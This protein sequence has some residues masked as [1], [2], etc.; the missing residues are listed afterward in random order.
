MQEEKSGRWRIGGGQ[1]TQPGQEVRWECTPYLLVPPDCPIHTCPACPV[2]NLTSP[3][4]DRN[5]AKEMKINCRLTDLEPLEL[6]PPLSTPSSALLHA[7]PPTPPLPHSTPRVSSHSHT[8]PCPR[9]VH[10]ARSSHAIRAHSSPALTSLSRRVQAQFL[11]EYK[12]V[13]VG[14][15]GVGKSSLTI[16]FI[17]AHFVDEYDPTIVRSV[18]SSLAPLAPLD[19]RLD[20]ERLGG[21]EEAG[22]GLG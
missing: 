12:L 19:S 6:S 10:S 1:K 3:A 8:Q 17:Q 16:Q 11:R 9:Y 22:E 4:A 18:L 20:R 13:V 7:P 2:L 5:K 14:G 15:G 21:K